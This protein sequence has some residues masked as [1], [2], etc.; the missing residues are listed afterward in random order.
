MSGAGQAGWVVCVAVLTCV[1]WACETRPGV[2]GQRA[3]G[4]VIKQVNAGARIPGTPAHDSVGVW[5]EAEL[6]RLGARVRVQ[7]FADSTLGHPLELSNIIGA[8]G[9]SASRRVA[10]MAHWDSRP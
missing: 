5:I 4:R 1:G 9:P 10:L 3:Y 8:Y 2:D 7:R 6:E